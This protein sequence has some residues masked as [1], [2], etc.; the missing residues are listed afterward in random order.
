MSNKET[1]ITY[2][3]NDLGVNYTKEKTTFRIWSPNAKRVEL[4]LYDKGYKSKPFDRMELTS[5]TNGTWVIDVNDDLHGVYYTYEITDDKETRTLVDPYAKACGVNGDRGMVIDLEKTN[6]NGWH[7]HQKPPLAKLTDAII[8]ESHIRDLTIHRSSGVQKPGTFLGLTETDT[9]SKE[10]LKTGLDHLVELGITHLHLLPVNDFSGINEGKLDQAQYNWGYQ[11]QNYQ[12]LEGSYSTNPIDGETRVNEFKQLVQTLHN[13]QIRVVLDI[14]F[15]YKGDI[16]QSQLEKAQPNYFY[17]VVDKKKKIYVLDVKKEMARKYIVDTL[18]YFANEYKVDGFSLDSFGFIDCQTINAIRA[19]LDKVDSRILL[20][21]NSLTETSPYYTQQ[22]INRYAMV[23]CQRIAI[24][25]HDG[26]EGIKGSTIHN[27]QPGFVNGGIDMEETLKLTISAAVEMEGINYEDV[28]YSKKPWALQPH[29][30]INY[31]SRHQG[32]TLFDKII[33]T[34]EGLSLDT[35]LKMA[36]M[37]QAIILTAQ[38]IPLLH[39]GDELLRSKSGDKSSGESPD[40]INQIVWDNK[41]DYEELFAYTQGLIELRKQHPAFRL[42]TTDLINEHLSF[43]P[44][45]MSNTLGYHLKNNA[46]GDAYPDIVVLFNANTSEVRFKLP[47][48]GVWN[49]VVDGEVAGVEVIRRF[50]DDSVVIPELS[51]LVLYSNEKRTKEVTVLKQ[52]GK[53]K[54]KNTLM[55]VGALGLYLLLRRKKRRK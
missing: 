34:T 50:T 49:V 5:D 7:D 53:S 26:S 25:N 3:G 44:S 41:Y 37:A 35:Q 10:G 43:I 14:S 46:N 28:L 39:A 30:T 21:G 52:E 6:P 20:Y 15:I 45:T 42:P 9:Q 51:T 31:V 18:T 36:K 19:E 27:Q 4:F 16:T 33:E 11:P 12:A 22:A 8:Y 38:G 1:L 24:L 29:Q 17:S 40:S 23:N 2:K 54:N 47:H 55:A 32:F 13:H 48:F